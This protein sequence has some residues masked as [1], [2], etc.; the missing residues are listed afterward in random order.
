MKSI[1]L[2][3]TFCLL[4][5]SDLS[6]QNDTTTTRITQLEAG[7]LAGISG[8][9]FFFVLNQGLGFSVAHGRQWTDFTIMGG[10]GFE[11]LDDGNLL[12][13]FLQ[14]SK[15]VGKRK[16]TTFRLKGGY[17][18]GFR[19]TPVINQEYDFRGGWTLQPA[20]GFR[21]LQRSKIAVKTWVGYKY[22]QGRFTFRPFAGNGVTTSV[23]HYHFFTL[24]AGF[25]F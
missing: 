24:N 19:D 17:A 11:K 14:I 1:T 4:L 2:L 20:V 21:L 10:V 9:G 13:I 16:R 5:T 25:E 8:D 7:Y 18:L 22:Q 23:F 15:P 12:P 6:A 3:L